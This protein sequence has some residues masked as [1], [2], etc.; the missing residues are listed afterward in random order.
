MGI[1][2][3]NAAF[4]SPRRIFSA[5]AKAAR[6]DELFTVAGWAEA[7]RYVAA[8]SGSSAPGKWSNSRAPYLVEIMDCLDAEHPARIVALKLPA[9]MGKSEAILNWIGYTVDA[10]PAPMGLGL[11]SLN[12]VQQW[13]QTKWTPTLEATPA[14]KEKVFEQTERSNRG[15]TTKFK[16]FRG[17]FLNVIS[18]SSPKELQARSWKRAAGDEISEWL[19]EV[20]DRGDPVDQF[21]ARGDAHADFKCLL[22]STPAELPDCRITKRHAAG[23]QREYYVPCP[24]CGEWQTIGID[25]LHRTEPG[26]AALACIAC[27]V[28]IDE[29]YKMPML[30]AA[31]WL[32]R[33]P[34]ADE[35][36]PA[37]PDH[38]EADLLPLWIA[39][40]GHKAHAE[41]RDPSFWLHQGYSPF[42]PWSRLL[43]ECDEAEKGGSEKKRAHQQQKLALAWDPSVDAPD[44]A[45]L[46]EIRGQ[47]VKRG[48]IPAWAWML[49]GAADVQNNRIEWAAYAWGPDGS[50]A[51]VDWGI[52]EG[53]TLTD[54]PWIELA[55]VIGRRWQGEKTIPLGFDGFG[56]DSGGGV[57]RTAKV[58]QFVSRA[59][60]GIYALKGS[61]NPKD[62]PFS[63]GRKQKAKLSTGTV[64]ARVDFIGGHGI[65]HSVMRML[66]RSLHAF[67]ADERLSHGLYLPI[68]APEEICRQLTAEVFVQPSS[69]KPGAIGQWQRLAARA[70]EHLDL[71]VYC[72]GLAWEQGL[73]RWSM[74]EW[75]SLMTKRAKLSD[76]A[77]LLDFANIE[78]RAGAASQNLDNPGESGPSASPEKQALGSADEPAEEDTPPPAAAPVSDIVAE[79]APNPGTAGNPWAI[80][81]PS[82][83][84]GRR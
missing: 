56:I 47:H 44:F 78:A 45:K 62:L 84:A 37:P 72:L 26:R 34:S 5:F 46:F 83:F 59:R 55:R 58:Y 6:P 71:A 19:A 65:K 7:R 76:E 35:T 33:Y 75:A 64:Y 67:E 54:A 82:P 49:T 16:A 42:K 63:Q 50:G 41:G 22:A 43:D 61:S 39:R 10:D 30:Q 68:E 2:L 52:I 11:P 17:G 28:L 27:G 70:N 1:E 48:I 3:K 73:H 66:D 69:R 60:S 29:A 80:A 4:A 21:I 32:K 51:L 81:S 36:N 31:L 40:R 12:E 38:F 25:R 8:E 79:R 18:T 53:D 15:S 9:Q 20:G 23:D 77:P 13:N 14:L 24:E 57:G 74:Q